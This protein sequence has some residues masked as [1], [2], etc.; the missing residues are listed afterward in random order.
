MPQS[1]GSIERYDSL[2]RLLHLL[3]ALG[4]TAEQMTSLVMIT[5][6]PGRVPNDWYA[7]HQSIGIILLGV[8][9]GLFLAASGTALAL[10][11]VPDVALSPAMHAVKETH[12]AAGPL[13]WAYLVLHPAM[14]ILHQLAG[15]DTLGRM[16]GH[17]R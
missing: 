7:F 10:T 4:I 13:M 11:I 12:E 9:I 1:P 15:H 3:I 14:A 2:S 6:K 8:L 5:P 16:F 17:G